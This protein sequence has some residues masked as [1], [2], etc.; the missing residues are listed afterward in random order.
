MK[1]NILLCAGGY[2]CNIATYWQNYV[3]AEK[4]SLKMDYAP[5]AM[6]ES[7]FSYRYRQK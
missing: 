5:P 1:T 4:C 7:S 3:D 2:G 6:S